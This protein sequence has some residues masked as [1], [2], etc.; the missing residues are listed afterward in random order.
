MKSIKNKIIFNTWIILVISTV[1]CGQ[2]TTQIAEN[3][4]VQNIDKSEKLF[5]PSDLAEAL[6]TDTDFANINSNLENSKGNDEFVIDKKMMSADQYSNQIDG[7]G[8][9]WG[10]IAQHNPNFCEEYNI[11]SGSTKELI[12]SKN[13]NGAL[14]KF[15]RVSEEMISPERVN[16]IVFSYIFQQVIVFQNNSDA[17]KFHESIK[18]TFEECTRTSKMIEVEVGNV[19]NGAEV[20]DKSYDLKFYSEENLTLR[21]ATDPDGFLT[22]FRIH[23]LNGSTLSIYKFQINNK[24]QSVKNNGW[25]VFNDLL[26]KQNNI[27]STIQGKVNTTYDLTQLA[28]YVPNIDKYQKFSYET[29]DTSIT[30]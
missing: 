9:A 18:N 28:T 24:N 1:A 6:F 30:E 2:Q 19:I 3:S 26:N 29:T 5:F 20:E 10:A 4:Q 17:A 23:V 22:E 12:N 16:E 8:F 15:A 21:S 25:A 13:I 7:Y 11:S 27:L 14:V